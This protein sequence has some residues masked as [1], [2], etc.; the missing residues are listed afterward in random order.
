MLMFFFY[1]TL[2]TTPNVRKLF[3]TADDDYLPFDWL[4]D[5]LENDFNLNHAMLAM[6]YFGHEQ[7]FQA[8]GDDNRAVKDFGAAKSIG[9]SLLDFEKP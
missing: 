3:D 6:A 1:L 4:I 5:D 8:L 7:Y 9:D 2:P